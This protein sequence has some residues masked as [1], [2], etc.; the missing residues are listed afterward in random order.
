MHNNCDGATPLVFGA[1]L[2][3]N[4]P[5]VCD[6]LLLLKSIK[7]FSIATAFFDPQY[8]GVLDKLAY[9]NEGKS[10][11][12]SRA[13]LTQMSGEIIRE[14]I[15]GIDAALKPGGHLFLWVDKFHLCEGTLPWFNGT[16]L[17]IVDM[18][19]WNKQTFGMGYR[20]RRTAEYLLVLQK[21]PKRARGVWLDHSIRDV[22]DER[23]LKSHPHAKPIVLQQRLIC[24]VTREDEW[25]LDPAA[26][27][28][29]VLLACRMAN[30]NFIGCD[31]EQIVLREDMFGNLSF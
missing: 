3:I 1:E 2:N 11:G 13:N 4:A 18:I 24:S 7:P 9:G 26:G 6:G 22:I 5:N 23:P 17:E 21:R 14:F 8:R 15:L 12:K 28:Y 20:S 31:I 29:S 16:K 19:V 10:R 25:V 27:S 30:R